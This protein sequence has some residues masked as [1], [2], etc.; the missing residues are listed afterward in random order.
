MKNQTI[1]VPVRMDYKTLRDFS[2]FDTF[3][4]RK[5]WIRPTIF[6]VA[7]VIF[8]IICFAATSKEQNWLLG[9]V[10]LLIGLGMP[11]VYVGMFLSGVKGQAKKLKLSRKVYTLSFSP[12]GVHISNDLKPEE[13][14]D[15]EWQKIPAAFRCRNA[16]YLYAAPTRAF[17][18]PDGQGDAS[19]DELW[20]M[21]EKH[22]RKGRAR[23]RR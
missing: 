8:A 20:A 22:L 7:F 3:I 21:M 11:A 13:Q 14:V 18:L 23:N 12:S 10:M 2:L 6:G 16:I 5:Q 1:I 15:L 9:T 17:I 4:L 19:P